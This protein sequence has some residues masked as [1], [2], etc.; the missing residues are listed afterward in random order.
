MFDVDDEDVERSHYDPADVDDPDTDPDDI[1]DPDEAP[2]RKNKKSKR[3]KPKT[4]QKEKEKE[5]KKEKKK[6]KKKD[7]NKNKNQNKNKKRESKSD[8]NEH[9]LTDLGQY[10]LTY[11]TDAVKG[12]RAYNEWRKQDPIN[13]VKKYK[14][15]SALTSKD[16]MGIQV[17]FLFVIFVI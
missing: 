4:K 3:K 15:G 6:K 16:L 5:K 10:L 2:K 12:D 13:M 17:C 9:E 8:W 11:Y 7:Q 1:Y 14:K